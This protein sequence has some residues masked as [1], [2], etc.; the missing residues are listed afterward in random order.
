MQV[1]L[2]D[3]GKKFK[4]YPDRYSLYF[5]YPKWLQKNDGLKGMYLGCSP[6]ERGMFRLDWGECPL[7]VTVNSNRLWLGKKIKLESMPE[8]FQICANKLIKAWNDALKYDDEKHW[9]A[10]VRA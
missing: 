6:T 8:N 1:R 10:W 5:P 3:A 9:D 7:G 2:Y 4:N